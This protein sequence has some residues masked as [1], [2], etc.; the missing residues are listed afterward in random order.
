SAL[1]TGSL[2]GLGNALL[3]A[4]Q[5]TVGCVIWTLRCLFLILLL[6]FSLVF[7][8]FLP[9]VHNFYLAFEGF[10]ITSNQ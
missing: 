10:R 7:G 2:S 8:V 3:S 6:P 1:N 9:L 4:W 5:G